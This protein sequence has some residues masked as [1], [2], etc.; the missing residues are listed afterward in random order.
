MIG[1]G[2]IVAATI[3]M[4]FAG[5]VGSV[6]YRSVGNPFDPFD[7]RRFSALEWRNGDKGDRCEMTR[8]LLE[9]HRMVGL[10]RDEVVALLGKPD[11]IVDVAGWDDV[12]DAGPRTYVYRV[13]ESEIGYWDYRDHFIE[14]RVNGRN[15]VE[16]VH[17]EPT[18]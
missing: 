9:H 4:P 18:R 12:P 2:L 14:L 15:V 5:A 13:G 1:K 7:N 6:V 11:E 17:F 8:D 16:D 10:A 3:L